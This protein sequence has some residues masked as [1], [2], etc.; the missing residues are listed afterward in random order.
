MAA[1]SWSPPTQYIDGHALPP[2]E[3]TAYRIYYGTNAGS[4]ARIA[5]VDGGT[6]AFAVRDLATGTHYFAVTAVSVS[7]S[8]S[9]YSVVGSKAIP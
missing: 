7:G 6:T 1:L 5:E 4:L 8:E 2:A 9:N 3:L